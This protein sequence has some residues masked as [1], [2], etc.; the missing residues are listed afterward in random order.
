MLRKKKTLFVPNVNVVLFNA[1]LKRVEIL[2]PQNHDLGMVFA[3]FGRASSARTGACTGEC[4]YDCPPH[5]KAS[6]KISVVFNNLFTTREA[7]KELQPQ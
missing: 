4:V 3:E 5:R 6:L 1:F 2:Q 7:K